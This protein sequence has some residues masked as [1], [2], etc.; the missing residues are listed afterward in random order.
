MLIPLP[1][2]VTWYSAAYDIADDVGRTFIVPS[3]DWESIS[4]NAHQP[5]AVLPNLAQSTGVVCR[6]GQ[7]WWS[8]ADFGQSRRRFGAGIGVERV[9]GHDAAQSLGAP[10][11]IVFGHS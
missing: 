3:K 5:A 7:P 9:V 8:T 10:G 11:W 6:C 2:D 1:E 4:G